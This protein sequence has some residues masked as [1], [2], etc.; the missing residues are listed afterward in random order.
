M[1]R[2]DSANQKKRETNPP[3]RRGQIKA[4]ILEKL[5]KAVVSAVS[6]AG[7]SHKRNGADGKSSASTTPSPSGYN[8]DA[9]GGNS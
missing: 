8:S 9:N 2:A 5:C 7:E 6:K 4:Q 1:G 3:P